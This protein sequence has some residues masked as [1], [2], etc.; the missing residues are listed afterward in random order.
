MSKPLQIPT[1]NFTRCPMGVEKEERLAQ[2]NQVMLRR[3][4]V[5]H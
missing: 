3:L 2:A 5:R 1:H 4:I